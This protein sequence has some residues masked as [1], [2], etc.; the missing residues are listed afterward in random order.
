[1][2]ADRAPQL[3]ASVMRFPPPNEVL[4]NLRL[5]ESYVSQEVKLS[6]IAHLAVLH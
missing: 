5:A 3:K 6:C 4:A 2:N 1:L